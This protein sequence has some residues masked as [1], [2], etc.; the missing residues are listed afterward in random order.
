MARPG[1]FSDITGNE[2]GRVFIDLAWISGASGAV[3]AALSRSSGIKSVVHGA[4]GVYVITFSEV[5][6][7]GVLNMSSHV[8]QA[9]YSKTGACYVVETAN[10][11]SSATPTVTILVTTAAGDAVEPT[12]SDVI[13]ITFELQAQK[14]GY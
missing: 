6:A 14:S 3:P 2:S 1:Y 7:N 10:A 4:T 12:T 13:G 5:W 8:R 11:I 9:S